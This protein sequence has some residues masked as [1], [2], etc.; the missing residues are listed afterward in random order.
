MLQRLREE[1]VPVITSLDRLGRSMLNMITLGA[2]LRERGIGLK[3]LKQTAAR[4]R[5]PKG[6]TSPAPRPTG[7]ERTICA[8]TTQFVSSVRG[9]VRL[10]KRASVNR[11]G[12]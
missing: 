7:A 10:P 2:D 1:D 9:W 5:I 3:V 4:I 12:R 8:L 11:R 6:P